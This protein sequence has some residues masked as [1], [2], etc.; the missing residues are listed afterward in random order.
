VLEGRDLGR[1]LMEASMAALRRCSTG[2]TAH[3][4]LL[5]AVQARR[6]PFDRWAKHLP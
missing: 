1:E 5:E 2:V 3:G 6:Q 4:G